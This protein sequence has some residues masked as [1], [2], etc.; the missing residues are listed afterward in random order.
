VAISSQTKFGYPVLEVSYQQDNGISA[1]FA[2][3]MWLAPAKLASGSAATFEYYCP[4]PRACQGTAE[5]VQG[6]KKVVASTRL[7]VAAGR[8]RAIKLALDK[9]GLSLLAKQHSLRVNLILT[10]SSKFLPYR[11]GLGTLTFHAK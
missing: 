5:A 9:T 7:T 3:E 4:G 2:L 11:T 8:S 6:A 1:S 10:G